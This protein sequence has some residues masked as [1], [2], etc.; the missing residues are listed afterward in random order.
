MLTLWHNLIKSETWTKSAM[1][2]LTRAVVWQLFLPFR[3]PSLTCQ[4]CPLVLF[5]WEPST[6]LLKVNLRAVLW[7]SLLPDPCEECV[8]PLVFR[9]VAGE[10]PR[11]L[12]AQWLSPLHPGLAAESLC[13]WPKVDQ[14]LYHGLGVEEMRYGY[15]LSHTAPFVGSGRENGALKK[16]WS[17][18]RTVLRDRGRSRQEL[19]DHTEVVFWVCAFIIQVEIA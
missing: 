12:V 15:V 13:S 19:W 9:D 16:I 11:T 7:L 18:P 5:S 4:K 10:C 1:L 8:S 6:E 17:L 2:F 3:W 14:W